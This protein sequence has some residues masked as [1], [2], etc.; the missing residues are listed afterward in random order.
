MPLIQLPKAIRVAIEHIDNDASGKNGHISLE[1][2]PFLNVSIC[3][4]EEDFVLKKIKLY[5]NI[6]RGK[7][8]ERLYSD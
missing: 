7:L 1:I 8:C 6:T 2:L 5:A 4:N 3:R